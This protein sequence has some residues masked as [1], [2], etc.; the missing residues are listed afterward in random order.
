[1]VL[2]GEGDFQTFAIKSLFVAVY[3]HIFYQEKKLLSHF[4]LTKK[5]RMDPT[6]GCA[7]NPAGWPSR[8]CFFLCGSKIEGHIWHGHITASQ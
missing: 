8:K 5:E 7:I 3:V 6:K 1:M 2:G 4:S